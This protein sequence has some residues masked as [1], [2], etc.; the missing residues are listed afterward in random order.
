MNEELFVVYEQIEKNKEKKILKDITRLF[1]D[2]P[3]SIDDTV[4]DKLTSLSEM[5]TIS[6]TKL[7]R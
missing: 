5:F 2:L 3:S 6:N 4:Y 1:P 7:K